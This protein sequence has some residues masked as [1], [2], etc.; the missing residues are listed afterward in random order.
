MNRTIEVL[1][2]FLK[3]VKLLGSASDMHLAN[4][5]ITMTSF[6]S[7]PNLCLV[8]ACGWLVGWFLASGF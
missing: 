5:M 6:F 4:L 3:K 2:S 1:G 8:Q 7:E